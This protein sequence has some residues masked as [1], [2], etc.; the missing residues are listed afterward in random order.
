MEGFVPF[1]PDVEHPLTGRHVHDFRQRMGLGQDLG[2]PGVIPPFD[3]QADDHGFQIG[4]GII[5][6]LHLSQRH[7]RDPVA[8]LADDHHQVLGHQLRKGFAQRADTQVIALLEPAH[9][10]FLTGFEHATDDVQLEPL[11]PAECRVKPGGEAIQGAAPK[12]A[13]NQ[14]YPNIYQTK[15]FRL[16]SVLSPK[17]KNVDIFNL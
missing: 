1:I 13:K 10:Q 14:S 9:E 3:G 2:F 6:I 8:F 7:G 4:A 17:H 15:N 12:I 16:K 5:D 11:I